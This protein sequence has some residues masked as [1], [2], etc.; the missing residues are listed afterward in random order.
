[1]NNI[2]RVLI[3]SKGLNIKTD[4]LFI[5]HSV[6]YQHYYIYII[7]FIIKYQNNI[8]TPYNFAVTQIYTLN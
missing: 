8:H 5:V 6:T 4:D 2:L 1:M 7:I 3:S